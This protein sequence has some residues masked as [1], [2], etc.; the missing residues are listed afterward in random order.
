M[1]AIALRQAQR[2]CTADF[3]ATIVAPL[4]A[5][6]GKAACFSPPMRRERA[7]SPPN[8]RVVVNLELP[9]NPMRL[10]QRIGRVDRIGQTR[11]VHAFHLI[12]RGTGEVRVLQRLG[13][14]IARAQADVGARTSQRATTCGRPQWSRDGPDGGR[15]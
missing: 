8:C 14:R 1:S 15:G 9:W 4:S 13:I 5:P 2:F 12:A 6:S 3:R 10:E 7:Q 11:R